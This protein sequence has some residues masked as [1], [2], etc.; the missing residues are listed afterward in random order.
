MAEVYT[1]SNDLVSTKIFWQNDIVSADANVLVDFYEVTKSL[2]PYSSLSSAVSET[3]ISS[4]ST[5][6]RSETDNGTYSVEIPRSITATNKKL[7]L[8]WKYSINGVNTS[9]STF[10]D[11]VTPYCSFAEAIEDLNFGTDASDP[12]YKTYHQLRMA[13]K[14][15]RKLIENYCGQDFYLYDD[16]YI[17]YGSGTN[18]LPL[19]YKVN[20]IYEIY[21]NDILLIDNT[22]TPVVNNWNYI[23]IITEGGFGLRVNET[24]HLDNTVYIA[25]GMIPPTVNDISYGGAFKNN[26]RY[27]V[28]AQF[29]W[30]EVPDNVEQAC[31]QLMGHFFDKDRAWKDQ[32]V[33]SVS[34]FDWKFDY[35]SDVHTGTGCSYADQLLSPY[36]INNM[37]VI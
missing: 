22:V 4:N 16:V 21:V 20:R 3:L 23:P 13:E 1:Y 11:V 10:C 2:D 28:S 15:A 18:L 19:P 29:G 25:N 7:K 8:V 6:I 26:Q 17:G 24:S 30:A 34:T 35:N 37:V 5:A 9:H 36:V 12:E 32:Y 14:Y 31:I 27:R 33:K